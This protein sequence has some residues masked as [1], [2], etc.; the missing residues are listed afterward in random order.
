MR[1][2]ALVW[3]L[4]LP[5]LA[6]PRVGLHDGFTRL[7]FDLPKA[8]TYTVSSDKGTLT[9]RFQGVR[10]AQADEDVD[11]GQVASY[12]VVPGADGTVVYVRLKPGAEAKTQV[13][14]D[15]EAKRL[16]VD[17]ARAAPTGKAST[18]KAPVLAPKPAAKKPPVVVIDPG[19]GGIDPG[20]VGYVIEKAITLDVGL[21]LKRLLEAEG[22]Q[23][24]MTRSRDMHL[25][26]D[27]RTDLGMRAA[28]TDSSKR[29]LF[30]SIHVNSAV[31]PAQGIEV[32][33]FG[34]T[35]SPS[36]LAQVIRENGGGNLGQQLTR[37]ARGVAQQA[38]R[39]V[40]AQANL[41]FSRRLAQMV[42]DSM[43]GVTGAVD[44]GVQSA[45]FYVIR[46]ARIPAILTEIG[47]ANH[48]QEGPRLADPN[49]REKLAQAMAQAIT[50]FLANGAFAQR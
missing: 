9:L 38:A 19:H 50:K 43:V 4:L 17:V 48:P 40:V 13:F 11:S 30:V 2:W 28:M 8:A 37:E 34:E 46:N 24:V 47:F 35:M 15:G 41:Q 45:P 44:R 7:V 39:D 12:Q 10:Q 22:I 25:S 3:F 21:R 42:H 1:F 5:A 18:P 31:R 36:L 23:V 33:Y 32:Y 20:A 26:T 27:K 6:F 29:N 16:I 49:Y 14:D